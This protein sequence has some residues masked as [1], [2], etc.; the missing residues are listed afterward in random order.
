MELD[1][2][3]DPWSAADLTGWAAA[4]LDGAEWVHIGALLRSDFDAETLRVAAGR[5]RRLLVDA[6]GLVRRAEAGPLRRDADVDP[7]VLE[8]VQVLKVSEDEA[9]L[10]A[11]GLDAAS[12]RALGVPEVVLTLGSEGSL[13]VTAEREDRVA[14]QPVRAADP[15][16]A[17]D[18][19]AIGYLAARAAGA[20]PADAAHAAAALVN[21]V[22]SERR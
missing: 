1:A 6:Q 9:M 18:T 12:L 19:Y 16:G 5:G 4:T 14:A 20:D 2:V 21:R 17:G 3:G 22:L 15:T 8:C 10:L 7:A 13:V 11:G